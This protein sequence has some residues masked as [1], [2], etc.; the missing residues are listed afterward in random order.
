MLI[1]SH[2]PRR[3]L[4]QTSAVVA[5]LLL[6]GLTGCNLQ[7]IRGSGVIVSEEFDTADFDR[8]EI[9]GV[10]EATINQADEHRVVV[11]IDDNLL[12]HVDVEVDDGVLKVDLDRGLSFF[13][14]MR[15]S[16]DTPT[17]IGVESSGASTTV[18]DNIDSPTFTIKVDGASTVVGHGTATALDVEVNG[19]SF[20]DLS[21]VEAT[22][23]KVD[24]N[25]AS[26]VDLTGAQTV[27]G[28]AN[29]ASEVIVATGA[30]VQIE[31][32]GAS[33]VERR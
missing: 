16:I 32:S 7:D 5:A 26:S 24:V 21:D 33:D 3:L 11:H 9:A 19:A 2:R 31:S 20:V 14:T 18:L 29:G 15:V 13:G 30:R 10:W 17:L 23:A 25:G 1:H 22:A 12:K 28:D 4:F 6:I 27:E 8:A